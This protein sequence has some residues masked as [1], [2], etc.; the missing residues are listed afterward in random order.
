MSATSHACSLFYI[1]IIFQSV[2]ADD[3]NTLSS[4]EAIDGYLLVS[5]TNLTNLRFLRNL[6]VLYGTEAIVF[7]ALR[8]T[9]VVEYN[10]L[11]QSY[12]FASIQLISGGGV[13]S[14]FNPSL[15]FLSNVDFNRY[16]DGNSFSNHIDPETNANC[17]T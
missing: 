2:S 17:S 11:L 14:L 3:L 13:L 4:I 5:Y 16:I 9:L 6:R 1:W 12:N 15:C 8:Y 10:N 7:R